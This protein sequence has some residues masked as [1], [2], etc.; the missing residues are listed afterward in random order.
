MNTSTFFP[1]LIQNRVT[2]IRNL[3]VVAYFKLVDANKSP[4]DTVSRGFKP[5]ELLS[6]RLRFSSPEFLTLYKDSRS[7]LKVG[8]KFILLS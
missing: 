8:D 5:A 1:V 6:S 4:A 7:S 2:E 3:V